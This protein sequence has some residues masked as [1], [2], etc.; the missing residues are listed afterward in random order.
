MEKHVQMSPLQ[1]QCD[2]SALAFLLLTPNSGVSLPTCTTSHTILVHPNTPTTSALT[3]LAA[4]LRL[5]YL[6]SDEE[7]Y[8]EHCEYIE[9]YIYIVLNTVIPD[10]REFIL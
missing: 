3:F 5:V 2:K 8:I 1:L 9:P 4:P 6:G 7:P 10:L